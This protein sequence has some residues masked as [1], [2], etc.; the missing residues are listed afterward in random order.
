[1]VRHRWLHR[2]FTRL[3]LYAYDELSVTGAVS[4]VSD[5]R[6]ELAVRVAARSGVH[7]DAV[8]VVGLTHKP[9]ND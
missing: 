9:N 8:A 4:P 5:G 7:T 6:T 3:R 2:L 1:M